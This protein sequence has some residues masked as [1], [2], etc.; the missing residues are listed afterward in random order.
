MTYNW[1]TN[2]IQALYT[3]LTLG[4]NC[5][6]YRPCSMYYYEYVIFIF[7]EMLFVQ[8]IQAEY[9]TFS[10]KITD[11]ISSKW[12]LVDLLAIVSYF[13]GFGLRVY[14]PTVDVG[15][16]IL[17]FNAG[18]WILRLLHMFYVHRVTGPYVVMIYRMVRFNPAGI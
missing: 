13:V 14:Q 18:I 9:S 1:Y 3:R 10:A 12:N 16:L 5:A 6:L 8:V 17:A 4:D 11:Y 15:H 7:N 2:G